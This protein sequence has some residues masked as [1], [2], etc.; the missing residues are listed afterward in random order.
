MTSKSKTKALKATTPK[1][2]VNSPTGYW[3]GYIGRSDS[4]K[5]GHDI[6]EALDHFCDTSIAVTCKLLWEGKDG[7][8]PMTSPA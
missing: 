6:V 3:L 1:K 8:A 4:Q 7:T 5:L 2:V